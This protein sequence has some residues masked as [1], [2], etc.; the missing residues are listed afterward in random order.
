[1]SAQAVLDLFVRR[2]REV[3]GERVVSLY[4]FGSL[5]EHGDFSSCSDVDVV[6]MLDELKGTDRD[7]V[8]ALWDEIKTADLEY[9]DRLS[10]FWASYHGDDFE[11]GRG[12]FPPLDRL[13]LIHHAKL[14]YG[15]DRRSELQEPSQQDM[16]LDSAQFI[17]NFMLADGKFD[18]LI[19][20]VES[21]L[22][23][24]ARYFTK[25][26]LFPVR[27]LFT[28]GNEKTIAS[29]KDAVAY[30]NQVWR[31][32]LPGEVGELVNFAYQAR[33]R[34]ANEPVHYDEADFRLALQSL[35]KATI[36]EY[37]SAA[38]RYDDNET[39]EKLRRHIEKID[40]AIA[41]Y[42]SSPSCS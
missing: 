38:A 31:E 2:A 10:L 33:S 41:A 6:L 40:V 8:T 22:S 37:A 18:E 5:G 30:F 13:D 26:V 42:D 11:S 29:N 32:R 17:S 21:V 15:E 20:D 36:N 14:L 9:A 25:F 35:Y 19:G 28:V 24:G 12:R 34:P 39:A 4:T 23:K 16:V 7:A 27:L 1:M 3:F